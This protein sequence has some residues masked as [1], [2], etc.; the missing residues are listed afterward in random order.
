MPEGD[1]LDDGEQS[2][3]AVGQEAGRPCGESQRHP[4]GQPATSPTIGINTLGRSGVRILVYA[5]SVHESAAAAGDNMHRVSHRLP[6]VMMG[7]SSQ[8][9]QFVRGERKM[10]GLEDL[11]ARLV[12]LAVGQR[13]IGR[14]EDELMRLRFGAALRE[15]DALSEVSVAELTVNAPEIQAGRESQRPVGGLLN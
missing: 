3:N 10:A 9:K 13:R 11:H 7:V 6:L 4:Q 2:E 15:K 14:H 5:G 12:R 1:D 8:V